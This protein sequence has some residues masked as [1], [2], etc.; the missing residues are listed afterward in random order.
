MKQ[1]FKCDKCG[2]TFA[3]ARKCEEHERVCGVPKG[4]QLKLVTLSLRF[5]NW[6]LERDVLVVPENDARLTQDEDAVVWN[7]RRWPR[8]GRVSAY[9]HPRD[10]GFDDTVVC[11]EYVAG[12][13]MTDEEALRQLKAC[14]KK[15]VNDEIA[16]R[17]L[18]VQPL[19]EVL[20]Q[21]DGLKLEEDK[22]GKH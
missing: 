10:G 17:L 21:I 19:R 6:R 3:D 1:L 8:K 2:R 13:G 4:K 15:E 22:N 5:E 20:G 7:F 14:A 16:G 18:R 12:G 9:R 11:A